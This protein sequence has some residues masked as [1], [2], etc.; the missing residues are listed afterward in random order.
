MTNELTED[1]DLTQVAKALKM[2]ERWVRQQVANGA[3]HMRYGHKIRFTAEQ[4]EMLRASCTK[5]PV[6]ASITTGRGGRKRTA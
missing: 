6:E 2:S 3:V 1:F 4:V 5:K